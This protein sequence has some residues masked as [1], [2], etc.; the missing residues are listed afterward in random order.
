MLVQW[1]FISIGII[2]NNIM[3]YLCSSPWRL[4]IDILMSFSFVICVI[5]NELP[6]ENAVFHKLNDWMVELGQAY[7]AAHKA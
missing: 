4:Y 2:N 7:S 5:L 1:S 6:G 3:V